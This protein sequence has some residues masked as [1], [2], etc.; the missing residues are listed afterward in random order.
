MKLRKILIFTMLIISF[1]SCHK[2]L[3]ENENTSTSSNPPLIYE[4]IRGNVMGYVYDENNTPIPNADVT[5]YSSNTT[6]D[7]KG[8]F[9]FKNVSLDVQGTY[10]KVEKSGYI[11]GSDM[12][13]PDKN[14]NY[15]YIKMLKLNDSGNFDA[16]NG[17]IV[18][19]EGGGQVSFPANIIADADG[20]PYTGNVK[21]TAKRISPDDKVIA[22]KMPGGLIGLTEEGKTV[23]LGT[24]GMVAI[25]LRD[26]NGNELNIL[27]GKKATVSF[28]IAVSQIGD[29]PETIDLWSF[30]EKNGIWKQ[31]GF[32]TKLNGEYIAEVSHFSFW[33]CDA[34]FPLINMCVKV[35]YTNG[36]P[37]PN[38][39]VQ[40]LAGTLGVGYSYTNSEGVV[41]GKI[42]KN[43][44][45]TIQVYDPWCNEIIFTDQIGPFGSDVIL[46][47]II[48]SNNQ[49]T[50]VGNVTC[51]GAAVTEGYVHISGNGN[52]SLVDFN[53]D[54]TFTLNYE[55]GLCNSLET[56]TL[57]AVNTQTGEGS[58]SIT[59]DLNDGNQTVVLETCANCDFSV[60]LV[61]SDIMPCEQ[62]SNYNVEVEGGSGNFS[63][64]WTDGSTVE[65]INLTSGL[66]CVT[67]TDESL[68][69]EVVKCVEVVIENDF[70]LSLTTKNSL[71]NMDNGSIIAVTSLNSNDISWSVNGIFYGVSGPLYLDNLAPGQYEIEAVTANGCQQF[72]FV[73]ILDEDLEVEIFIELNCNNELYLYPWTTNASQFTSVI[74]TDPQGNTYTTNDL[75]LTNA[76]PGEYCIIITDVSGCTASNCL[77]IEPSLPLNFDN[78]YYCSD[79]YYSYDIPDFSPL[80]Y[81]FSVNGVVLPID[82]GSFSFNFDY[83]QLGNQFQVIIYDNINNCTVVDYI[84]LQ[85]FD[86]LEIDGITPPSSDISMDGSINASL[87]PSGTCTDCQIGSLA[88]LT[89]DGNEY[90]NVT[91]NNGNYTSGTYYVVALDVNGCPVASEQID[92]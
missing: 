58:P 30:D 69:C 22:D 35:I 88:I 80:S 75:S 53:E 61:H 51:L 29:A 65:S 81:D 17:G 55:N 47:D 10:V 12:L 45:L 16:N 72:D 38:Y 4:E 9:Y 21:V 25:E 84:T 24:M 86:G 46:D 76:N 44:D 36:D 40:V 62:S 3:E 18:N 39:L 13:Y 11:L 41:C 71:C 6:T 68:D 83:I 92:L 82:F 70:Q 31:E 90:T 19:I 20:S 8:V 89:Y 91:G 78:V 48:V 23:V 54:G 77:Y 2:D 59:I 1:S 42:P 43:T 64:L 63:Y 34:P 73:E 56:L 85:S 32:A 33:N 66:H 52:T 27:T 14:T 60:E 57:F 50:I 67:V 15:S 79:Y 49:I 37:A 74:W 87:N 5:I 28:P 26:N 7:D